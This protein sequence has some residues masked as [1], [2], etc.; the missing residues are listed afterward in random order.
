VTAVFFLFLLHLAAGMLF[1]LCLV[2]HRAGDRFFKLCAASAAL[3]ARIRFNSTGDLYLASSSRFKAPI[4]C[5][6]EIEPPKAATA[7]CTTRLTASWL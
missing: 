4:P 1:A 7:S 5:S 2:P 3:M 6:A